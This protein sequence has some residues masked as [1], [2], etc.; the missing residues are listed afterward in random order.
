MLLSTES[1]VCLLRESS[2]VTRASLKTAVDVEEEMH[3]WPSSSLMVLMSFVL[4][5]AGCSLRDV[6][7]PPNGLPDGVELLP[8]VSGTCCTDAQCTAIGRVCNTASCL[9]ELPPCC[10]EAACQT[11]AKRCNTGTCLCEE[12]AC[13][14]AASC[15][16]TNQLCNPTSCQCEATTCCTEQ[17]CTATA[18]T[19]NPTTC[20]CET[21]TC[22]TAAQCAATSKTCNTTTCQCE[23]PACCT[24]ALCAASGKVCNATSCQCEAP[25]CCT[26][27][28]CS[29]NGE[30]C[31]STSCQCE[32]CCDEFQ[33]AAQGKTCNLTTCQCA[34][35]CCTDAQCAQTGKVCNPTSCVCETRQ[36]CTSAQCAP[37][38]KVCNTTSCLCEAPPCCT[39]AQCA[40]NGLT[41][42]TT[43]CQ[44]VSTTV[45]T[46]SQVGSPCDPNATQ[47]LSFVCVEHGTAV[48][49]CRTFC[50]IDG[51][52]DPCTLGTYCKVAT[53]QVYGY[54]QPSECTSFFNNNCGSGQRCLPNGNG[55]NVCAPTGTVS[56]GNACSGLGDCGVGLLCV[57]GTCQRPDCAALSGNPGCL[58]GA[59]CSGLAL[60][61]EPIDVG[62]C[63]TPCT[64]FATNT[65]SGGWCEPIQRGTNGTTMEGECTPIAGTTAVG[66]ACTADTCVA[67]ALC[68]G[69]TCE[70]L[71]D[72]LAT[73]GSGACGAGKGCSLLQSVDS[74]GQTVDLDYGVCVGSCD[75]HANVACTDASLDC[76]PGE[77]F[78]EAFDLCLET[79]ISNWPLSEYESCTAFGLSEY[80]VCATNSICLLIPSID[81]DVL[82]YDL[83][84]TSEQGFDI[85]SHPDC[86]GVNE[87]CIELF[88]TQEFGL[89]N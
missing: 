23:T 45:S 25:P 82:C 48:G 70:R 73:S 34:A 24:A 79:P 8:D 60:G 44:C 7:E 51:V 11:E 50:S 43:S 18:K 14:T 10:T 46:C 9:C 17:Q 74:S 29:A 63:Y 52:P 87:S 85:P 42:N 19:C 66:S 37:A 16:A 15:A 33:C 72:P 28:E 4:L 64:A 6:E 30:R 54:C 39:E 68:I 61:G 20:Q 26:A 31:N 75:F 71:C 35:T 55:T 2:L 38:G 62:F 80:D 77:L 36:C 1:S 49:I 58:V 41:C 56:E 84:M 59:V 13:C 76:F 88:L 40:A 57:S 67:G 53:G 27:A 32:P 3:S 22:C 69:G 65:C 89:C 83:C 12:P 47:P 81:A 78:S 86:R 21:P 5:F